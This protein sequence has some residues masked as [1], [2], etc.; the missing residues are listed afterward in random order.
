MFR[1]L[2]SFVLV[3]LFTFS[4]QA[5]PACNSSDILSRVYSSVGK[6]LCL[7]K[8][9]HGAPKTEKNSDTMDCSGLFL[10]LAI[11]PA[12]TRATASTAARIA[13]DISYKNARKNLADTAKEARKDAAYWNKYTSANSSSF[14][15]FAGFSRS[16]Y[17]KYVTEAEALEYLSETLPPSNAYSKAV[18]KVVSKRVVL[19]GGAALT[20]FGVLLT[21]ADMFSP[22]QAACSTIDYMYIDTKDGCEYLP[23]IGPNTSRFLGMSAQEQD[24]IMKDYPLICESYTQLAEKLE[25]DLEKTFPAPEF[26]VTSCGK[27]NEVTG[28]NLRYPNGGGIY[29]LN[30]SGNSLA[31]KTG[32]NDRM[33]YELLL[34]D[35]GF[36]VDSVSTVR[37]T[38]KV[39]KIARVHIPKDVLKNVNSNNRTAQRELGVSLKALHG[40]TAVKSSVGNQCRSYLEQQGEEADATAPTNR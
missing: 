7:D 4:A 11:A 2:T 36:G 37:A 22:T 20:G 6:Y 16:E 29:N 23:A 33:N 12:A 35:K 19:Y 40:F 28:A 39:S 25:S 3:I 13:D 31:V 27:N 5:A 21:A 38:V 18:A 32:T 26:Q 10:G 17:K 8:F 30:Q 24:K 34:Q 1:Q 15:D 9:Y 14:K